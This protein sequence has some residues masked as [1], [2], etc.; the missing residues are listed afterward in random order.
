MHAS[1]I[2]R[3]RIAECERMAKF[4]HDPASGAIWKRMA[5]RW[6]RCAEFETRMELET[7]R[8]DKT[9]HRKPVPGWANQ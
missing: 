8:Q 7:A 3:D 1:E 6:K 9:R 2:F 5:E 4:T